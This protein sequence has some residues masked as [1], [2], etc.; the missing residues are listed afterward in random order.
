MLGTVEYDANCILQGNPPCDVE[1][2][3][4]P[5]AVPNADV[6]VN[7]IAHQPPG[8]TDL[9]DKDRNL[10]GLGVTAAWSHLFIQIKT[11]LHQVLFD[12]L[13]LINL[14]RH[15]LQHTILLCP[16]ST[17][18]EHDGASFCHSGVN[19]GWLTERSV[20]SCWN[21]KAGSHKTGSTKVALIN[22]SILS[23]PIW[24]ELE[25]HARRNLV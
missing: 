3:N 24:F 22:H 14:W 1:R 7:S 16:R 2:R 4:F 8:K 9:V 19:V 21:R 5:Q 20:L 18:E 23:T 17:E 25:T 12:H 6:G 13:Q 15:V 10:G 11:Q